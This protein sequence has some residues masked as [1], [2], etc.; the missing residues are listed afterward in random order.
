M[1]RF[2]SFIIFLLFSCYIFSSE[3]IFSDAMNHF[4][5][6]IINR[7]GSSHFEKESDST[8]RQILLF[9]DN[10]IFLKE[11]IP[12]VIQGYKIVKLKSVREYLDTCS[13]QVVTIYTIDKLNY[14]NTCEAQFYVAF[15]EY[16]AIK[17]NS[18]IW[19]DTGYEHQ[20][21]YTYNTR[22]GELNYSYCSSGF[23]NNLHEMVRRNGWI[24]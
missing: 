23:Y 12:E 1:I 9:E 7:D 10:N 24:K 14:C 17:S 4:I 20:V 16:Y 19:I 6:E 22:K 18:K 15:G 13:N 5:E 3:S 11:N 21:S 2:N 8:Y